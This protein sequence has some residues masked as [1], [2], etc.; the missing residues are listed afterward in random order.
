M[1]ER[2]LDQILED[3]TLDDNYELVRLIEE[4]EA[5]LKM[6]DLSGQ[7]NTDQIYKKSLE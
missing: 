4:S 2:A 6:N 7:L 1:I 5:K 3:A